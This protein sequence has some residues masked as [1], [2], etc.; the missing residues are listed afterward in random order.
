VGYTPGDLVATTA[1]L[2][3]GLMLAAARRIPEADRYVREGR[4]SGSDSFSPDRLLG[5]D[6]HGSTLGIVG[7]GAIGQAVARRALAFEM[8]VL[9][10]TPSGREVAGVE[11]AP[12]DQLLSRSDYLSIHVALTPETRGLIDARAIARLPPGA[13]LVNTARGGIV[14]EAALIDALRRGALA[15]AALD[16]FAREPIS[17]TDPLLEAPNLVLTPHIGSASLATRTRMADLAIDNLLAGLEGRALP[18]CAN[19]GALATG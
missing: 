13:F 12:L 6:L 18:R 2:S 10:W 9:G 5:R 16:V 3:M 11:S 14:D 1:E 19:S 15:G 17:P 7:L 4:W 8:R